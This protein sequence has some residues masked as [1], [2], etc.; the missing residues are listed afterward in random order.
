[1]C[2]CYCVFLVWPTKFENFLDFDAKHVCCLSFFWDIKRKSCFG[3]SRINTC[4]FG[5][6]FISYSCIFL[7]KSNA[8][9]SYS[10]EI[11]LFFKNLIFQ[12]FDRSKLFFDRSKMFLK[13]LKSFWL[14]RSVLDWFGS[15]EG[16]FDRSNLFFDQSKIGLMSF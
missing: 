6:H 1:M 8:L 3:G 11:G 5:K 16:I 9:R 14:V 10:T 4:V 2:T 13:S 15:I 7:I 12:N